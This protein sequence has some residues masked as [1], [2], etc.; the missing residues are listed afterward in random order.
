MCLKTSRT[1]ECDCYDC[2]EARQGG[3][4]EPT[5]GVPE[6]LESWRSAFHQAYREVQVEIFKA[7][8]KAGK[9]AGRDA[10]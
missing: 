1:D 7:K 2:V 8:I 5:P 6:A 9:E 10:K 4:G 3:C